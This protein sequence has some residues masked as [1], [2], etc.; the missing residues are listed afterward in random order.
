MTI[1]VVGSVAFDTIETPAERREQILGGAANYFSLAASFFSPVQLV[2]VVGDDFPQ[3]HLD[4]LQ[5]RGVDLTG[6]QR[7]PGKTFHWSG[8]YGENCNERETLATDLNVYADFRPTLPLAYRAARYVFLANIHPELQ[9]EVLDQVEAPTFVAADTMN[10]WI[11]TSLD[12][13]KKVLGRVDALL[14]NEGEARQIGGTCNLLEAG[15]AIAAMGPKTVVIKLG[16]Y[17]AIILQGE[18]RRFVPAFPLSEVVDPTGAGDTF[19]GGFLGYIARAGS[20]APESLHRAAA[21]GS[22]LG[23]F[24]C[25]DFGIDRLKSLTEAEIEARFDAL[26]RYAGYDPAPLFA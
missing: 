21:V 2:A 4:L 6:L 5:G 7:V 3:E 11:D 26:T 18:A 19:G 16:E 13:L 10:L 1:L 17:G 14:L 25:Q 12:T 24:V 23:S 15:R 20:T 22:V 8:R 9:L